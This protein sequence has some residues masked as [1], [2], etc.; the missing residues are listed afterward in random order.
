MKNSGIYSHHIPKVKFKKILG[1]YN[2]R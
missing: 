2:Y 1:V